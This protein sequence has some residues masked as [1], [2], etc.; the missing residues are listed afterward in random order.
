[1]GSY[2]PFPR[3]DIDNRALFENA[4][5]CSESSPSVIGRFDLMRLMTLA[6]L[7]D[8]KA[9]LQLVLGRRDA[10]T[11]TADILRCMIRLASAGDTDPAR[12]APRRGRGR[13][14]AKT[15]SAPLVEERLV[16][17]ESGALRWEV[18][19]TPH[20]ISERTKVASTVKS[21]SKDATCPASLIQ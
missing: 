8:T 7:G 4:Y 15:A 17:D 5:I 9:F 10:V 21:L 18:R 20:G 11:L 1:M 16:E 13:H 2:R 3:A 19:L 6:G 12:L 14:R